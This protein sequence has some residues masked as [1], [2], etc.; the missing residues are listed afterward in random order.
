MKHLSDRELQELLDEADAGAREQASERADPADVEAYRLVYEALAAEPDE[1][2]LSPNFAER[3]ARRAFPPRE[4]FPWLEAA[5]VPVALAAALA[6]M[7]LLMPAEL[8]PFLAQTL[9]PFLTS[10]TNLWSQAHLDLAL[11]AGLILIVVDLVDRRLRS[12]NGSRR[13]RLPAV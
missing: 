3:V 5:G 2:T 12:Q 11:V 7:L 8:I 13:H 4:G 10:F 1:P 9:D 6:L